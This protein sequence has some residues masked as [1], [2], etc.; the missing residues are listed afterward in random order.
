LSQSRR[1]AGFAPFVFAF[2]GGVGVISRVLRRWAAPVAL[3]LGIVVQLAYPG[4]FGSVFHGDSPS[5]PAWV[6]AAGGCAA[7]VAGLLTA[8][9]VPY[10]R[11]AGLA[12]ALFL[13]PVFVHG[14]RHWSPT[15]ARP[16]SPLTSGLVHALR[17]EVPEGAIVYSDPETSYRI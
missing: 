17:N 15:S 1:F 16:P 10:E 5:W 14:F 7:L 3:G 11:S 13:L 6:A 2:A 8:R 9:R 4:D 12:V